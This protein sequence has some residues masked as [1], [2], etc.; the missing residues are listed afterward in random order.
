VA[1][2]AWPK[3]LKG[4]ALKR[5]WRVELGPSYSGPV[6]SADLVFV[7]ETRDRSKEV[8]RALD[9]RTGK[10]RWHVAWKAEPVAVP[11]YARTNGDWIRSTPA[12]DGKHLYVAG[13]RD[14][15]VCLDAATG[16][17][18]WRIDFV[19]S[20]GSRVP[21]F[22]TVSSP[23]VDGDGVFLLAGS[24][25][26][27]VDRRTGKVLWRVLR[28]REATTTYASVTSSPVLATLAGKRQVV[29]QNRKVLAGVDPASGKVY[30]RTE[31]PS[32]RG[33]NVLTPTV[34]EPDSLF[35]SAFGG[36]SFR[37]DV[38]RKGAGLVVREA[39]DSPLQG[40]L[41]SPVVVAGH[42]YLH[43]RSQ[44]LACLDLRTGKERWVSGKAFGRYWSMVAH[45]D[46]ILALDQ[47][48]IL[49]L[50]EANPRKF[51]L[52]GQRKVSDQETWAHLAVCG[53]ELYVRELRALA[54][55]RWRARR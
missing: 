48:G 26:V 3:T 36:R 51:T 22:G 18:R 7:T 15:L 11:S 28:E 47:R 5:L 38:K 52:L 16:K 37:F 24:S 46:S 12:Y 43:L 2:P 20:F 4:D 50:L 54:A 17:E 49:Y 9:R 13:M 27:K 40:Y 6:V 55:Y 1:G 8:V 31:V 32:F 41:S 35:T 21:V 42:A 53:D 45:G 33:T 14:V 19:K 29:A 44:R 25:L 23:L 34:C 10:E 39:W 30:W